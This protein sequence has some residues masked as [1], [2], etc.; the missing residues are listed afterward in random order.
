MV[1]SRIEMGMNR[2]TIFFGWSTGCDMIV[3]TGEGCVKKR[4]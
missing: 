1:G 4:L 3:T 2:E